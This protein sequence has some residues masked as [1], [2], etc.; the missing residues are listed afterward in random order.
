[1]LEEAKR[2][3]GDKGGVARDLPSHDV[4]R[5]AEGDCGCLWLEATSNQPPAM[6]CYVRLPLY[7]M[8]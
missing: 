2:G 1:M 7:H 6:S 4:D 5:G 8:S 3:V